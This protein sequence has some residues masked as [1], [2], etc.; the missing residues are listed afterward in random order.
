VARPRDLEPRVRRKLVIHGGDV[1][2]DPRRIEAAKQEFGLLAIR[3]RVI[4]QALRVNGLATRP[5]RSS[6]GKH[7]MIRS[8][9]QCLR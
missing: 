9:R 4:L 8:I 2:A 3:N 5:R 6:Q 7:R 1:T